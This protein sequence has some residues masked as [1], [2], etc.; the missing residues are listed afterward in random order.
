MQQPSADAIER[1][2]RQNVLAQRFGAG[3][4][5]DLHL[6]GEFIRRCADRAII[7]SFNERYRRAAAVDHE[8]MRQARG[9]ESADSPLV[10]V[11]PGVTARSEDI[12]GEPDETPDIVRG[13]RFDSD[14]RTQSLRPPDDSTPYELRRAAM[15]IASSLARDGLAVTAAN[16]AVALKSLLRG[17]GSL[18]EFLNRAGLPIDLAEMMTLKESD[19]FARGE[20]VTW[21]ECRVR[22]G[23]SASA[24]RSALARAQLDFRPT[25]PGFIATDDSGGD[26]P[27]LF[28]LQ[29]TRGDDWLGE[30]DGG[31]VDIARQLVHLLPSLPCVISVRGDHATS[32][33]TQATQWARESVRTAPITIISE[34]ATL[35]QWAQDNA[36]AGHLDRGGKH[37]AAA[38]LPR[39]ASRGEERSVLVPGDSAAPESLKLIGVEVA[40]S[41]LLF[42][43]GNLIVVNDRRN[44]RRVLL[45]GEAE[46]YRNV[47]LGL[48]RDQTIQALRAE[49]AAD[50]AIQLPAASYHIDSEVMCVSCLATGGVAAYVS[51]SVAGARTIVGAGVSALRRGGILD[52]PFAARVHEAI[53]EDRRDP[54][55]VLGLWTRLGE[56]QN[57]SGEF[58]STLS[59]CFT[60]GT[61]GESTVGNFL[62]FL[63]ALDHL[64][65]CS[66]VGEHGDNNPH[67]AAAL[68]ARARLQRDRRSLHDLL[69]ERG[70]RVLP[71]PS[72]PSGCRGVCGLNGLVIPNQLLVPCMSGLF[73]ALDSACLNALQAFGTRTQVGKVRSA[74]SQRRNGLL[75]CST[76][77]F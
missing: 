53:G 26:A 38:L 13:A 18:R 24:I 73:S 3:T 9:S 45:V 20:L 15:I 34:R 77:I 17:S 59:R 27:L 30:G 54:A 57:A 2:V 6:P 49:F 32:I 62:T 70:W 40:R 43:G 55:A 44:S 22:N 66:S 4:V 1:E 39:Y 33:A 72:F 64:T 10:H 8:R 56:F 61:P 47:A 71:V 75:R 37:T 14:S 11:I 23:A 42:Q 29:L 69:G 68:H 36:R 58:D 19:G 50:V 74:E 48:S 25:L 67:A 65:G 63:E 7:T 52:E 60:N 5:G 12:R 28:R 21:L 51:D 46:V 16:A 41:P 31:S 76:G 35:S